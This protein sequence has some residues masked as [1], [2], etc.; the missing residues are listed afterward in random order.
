MIPAAGLP[1]AG[2][3]DAGSEGDAGDHPAAAVPVVE[4]GWTGTL[5]H[6]A[7]EIDHYELDPPEAAMVR[8]NV[9]SGE[10][11]SFELLDPEDRARDHGATGD[12]FETP[13]VD[14][15][16]APQ[17]RWLL[18]FELP[19]AISSDVEVPYRFEITYERHDNVSR[20]EDAGEVGTTLAMAFGNG[21]FQAV[22]MVTTAPESGPEEPQAIAHQIQ[23]HGDDWAGALSG[24][25]WSDGLRDE[26]WARGQI[27]AELDIEEPIPEIRAGGLLSSRFLHE[28]G[29]IPYQVEI[30]QASTGGASSVAWAVWDDVSPS[31]IFE[32][33]THADFTDL[34][35][36]HGGQGVQVGPY[37]R[38][39][40]VTCSFELTTEMSVL[41][42][43]GE[44]PEQAGEPTR[45][46]VEDPTGRTWH[47][48]DDGLFRAVHRDDDRSRP[49][50]Q[51][52]WIVDVEHL[53]GVDDGPPRIIAASF[54][55]PNMVAELES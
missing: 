14:A 6:Q 19:A 29:S 54:P 7:D 53:D 26:V 15:I 42:V 5:V 8:V 50:P 21:S 17:G 20:V 37:A 1:F 33:G 39:S 28:N 2:Q 34:G 36:C 4:G 46:R 25:G 49:L 9:G 31:P 11:V 43:R 27:P 24:V 18:R 41:Q 35:D 13:R 30:G 32:E 52:T 40:N 16:A 38:A 45:L 51:G 23:Y 22:E 10:T 12:E 55:I 44:T 48:Q 47:R 3:D